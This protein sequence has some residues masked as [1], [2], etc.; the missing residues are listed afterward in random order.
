MK[1]EPT[2][3]VVTGPTAVGKTHFA[4]ELANRLQT[5]IISADSRQCYHELNIGVARPSVSELAQCKHH[6]IASH[7]IHES[8]N[9]GFFEQ[10]A[11]GVSEKILQ[12][13]ESLVIVGG[14]GLYINAFC[15]GIDPMPNVPVSIRTEIIASYEKF[16]LIWLQ[17]E[18]QVKDPNFW[19]QA[20]QQNPH[21]LIRALEVLLATGKS[22]LDF[23]KSKKIE[24]PFKIVKIGLEIPKEELNHRIH[25]RVDKMMQDGLAEEAADLVNFRDLQALQTVGYKEL[26][27]YLSSNISL[28]EAVEKIKINTRHYAKRQMTWFKKDES[29]QW[30][31]PK[32]FEK[33]PI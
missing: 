2:V 13:K 23:R 26:F 4:I 6:F 14:T 21:R 29:I 9:A 19:K 30:M 17:K 10:F 12:E 27:D 16:G 7:S 11:L 1:F 24:R 15:H 31:H 18:L 8:L 25:A 20:E 32:D 28:D 5:E 33:I 3:W 22:I